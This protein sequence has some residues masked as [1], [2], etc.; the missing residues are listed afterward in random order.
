MTGVPVGDATGDGAGLAAT[1]GIGVGLGGSGFAG[2]QAAV[3]AIA[4]ARIDM[5]INDLLMLIYSCVRLCLDRDTDSGRP[6]ADIFTA[7]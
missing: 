5:D 6:R 4:V 7:G 3:T 2:S 1:V